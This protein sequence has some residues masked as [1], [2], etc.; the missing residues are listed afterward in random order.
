MSLLRDLVDREL[1]SK[2]PTLALYDAALLL[3]R[4]GLEHLVTDA[5]RAEVEALAAAGEQIKSELAVLFT[6][7]DRAPEVVAANYDGGLAL[8][9]KRSS[10]RRATLRA[11]AETVAAGLRKE[12]GE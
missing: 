10:D 11:A 2:N 5:T 9:E 6:T 12:S 1:F 3:R 4:A 7:A 8:A